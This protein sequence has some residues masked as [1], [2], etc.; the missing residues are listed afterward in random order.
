MRNP[1]HLELEFTILLAL[2]V[3]PLGYYSVRALFALLAGL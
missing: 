1:T 2:L 3:V